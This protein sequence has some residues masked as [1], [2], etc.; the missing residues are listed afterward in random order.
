M[1][2]SLHKLS[3]LAVRSLDKPGRHSDGGGLYLHITKDGQSA[4]RRWIFRYSR[5]GRTR[6]LGLGS[7]RDLS[8]ANVRVEAS[9][10]REALEQGL[11]PKEER[12]R[13]KQQPTIF[14][15]YA[16]Q[17][18]AAQRPGWRNEKH[19]QQW[20]MTITKYAASLR[21]MPLDEI[22]TDDV[23][24]VLKPR[25]SKTPETAKRLQ[26]RIEA[27]LD[28]AKANGLR[29]GDNPARWRGHLDK[30][31]SKRSK[32]TRGHH[33]ALPFAELPQFIDKLSKRE[34]LAA[35][36]LEFLILTVAR[37]GD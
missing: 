9:K 33:A 35:R 16:D 13:S 27:I 29:T 4:R 18:I 30:L 32:L 25:W 31:L 28:A 19:A 21:K 8:L 7:G 14:G 34:A 22:S 12:D 2:R 23:L 6:E 5:F 17:Y 37:T 1:A 10:L 20:E 26:S 36:A 15:L 3:A 24:A 11:D